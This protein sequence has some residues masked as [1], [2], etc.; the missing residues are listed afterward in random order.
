[1]PVAVTTVTP[2]MLR[3]DN[4][5]FSSS[6]AVTNKAFFSIERS[7]NTFKKSLVFGASNAKPSRT[8][9]FSSNTFAE[10]AEFRAKRRTFLG[11]L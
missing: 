9:K 10:K 7:F 6:S 8:T 2:G 1:M 5:T 4:A 11:N 3:A